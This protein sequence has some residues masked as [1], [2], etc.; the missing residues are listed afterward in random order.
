[1]LICFPVRLVYSFMFIFNLSN[2]IDYICPHFYAP[3]T[4]E[5]ENE[6]R[7]LIAKIKE[8]AKNKDLKLGITEWNHT[9]GHWGWGRSW[10]L[11]LY[12]ALNAGRMF[13]M[14]HRLGDS[15]KIANR[16]NMTNSCCSGVLQ[17]N[18]KGEIYFTP[19]YFVQMA[20]ANFSGDRALK[21]YNDENDPLDVSATLR[22]D[23]GDIALFA[24]NYLDTPLQRS[25]DVSDMGISDNLIQTWTLSGNSLD[26]L[27][28]FQEKDRVSPNDSMVE[29][30]GNTLE[31]EFSPYS[32]TV[33]RFKGAK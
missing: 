32:L 5:R 27:N 17:T 9:A 10:L 8:K 18:Q 7:A 13:N 21:I 20:Y 25:I 12:N 16:S 30:K 4:K 3:Y 24:V 1:M 29:L 22:D 23:N 15:V 2:E 19:C 31:Y 11:T 14:Y 6:L 33:L 26:D 28:S